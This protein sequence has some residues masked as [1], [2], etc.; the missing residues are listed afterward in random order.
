MVQRLQDLKAELEAGV[1]AYPPSSGE[2][3]YYAKKL[4]ALT[5]GIQTLVA[6][7]EID[8]SELRLYALFYEAEGLRADKGA[9]HSARLAE[10][11]KEAAAAREDL[12]SRKPRPTRRLYPNLSPPS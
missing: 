12:L 9:N 1:N 4:A 5:T 2:H 8:S 3:K 6:E 11:E 10:I 7:A